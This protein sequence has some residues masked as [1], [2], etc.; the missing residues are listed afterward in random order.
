MNCQRWFLIYPDVP[1][2]SEQ[3]RRR[4]RLRA[5]DPTVVSPFLSYHIVGQGRSG[6]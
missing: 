3:Q 2:L 6:T 4:L 5:V 1:F